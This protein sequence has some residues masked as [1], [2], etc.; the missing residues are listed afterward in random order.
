[1]C[2]YA[3]HSPCFGVRKDVVKKKAAPPGTAYCHKLYHCHSAAHRAAEPHPLSIL[4]AT[5][6]HTVILIR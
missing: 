2:F 5:D 3:F 1:M 6:G 4:Y